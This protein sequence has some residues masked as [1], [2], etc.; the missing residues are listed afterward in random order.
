MNK[1]K[2]VFAQ[3]VDFLPRYEFD[4]I[5]KKYGGDY[6]YRHLTS[7]NHLLHLIFGQL[8]ACNSLR[9][10]CLCLGAHKTWLYHLGF[11]QSVNESSLSR[12]GE[13]RDYRIFEEFG[14]ILIGIARPLYV[15]ASIPDVFL[16]G[17]EVFALDST[18]ISCSILLMAWAFGKY[19]KGAV[20]MH[21]MLDL[22][23][24][25]P[26]FIHITHG[27]WHDSNVL[28]II[29]II[30]LAIYV[31]DKAYVDFEALYRIHA[32]NAYFVT[33]AKKNM[34]YEV[35][36]TNYNIDET[37]GLRGDYTIK[38]TG[39]KVKR[40][41]PEAFRLVKYYDCENDE[42]LDF[43]T[44]NLDIKALDVTNI[45]RN[46]WQIETFFKWIKGNLIIKTLW[47]HS[48]NAVKIHLW[49]AVIT[50]LLVSIIRAKTNSPYTITEVETLLRN[51]TF[52][53]MNLRDLLTKPAE[54][55]LDQNQNV[56]ELSLF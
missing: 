6:R 29:D 27:K 26:A 19:E 39:Y 17:W 24:S 21:T 9:D 23:G 56:K 47:G 50:Y 32:N 14:Y 48:E 20:K 49:V 36:E 22:R 40:F 33:R 28:D 45:Y 12:A 51:S 1:G 52:E 3:V 43:I 13:N 35:I 44:N 41:Y 5:V 38:L 37:T 18:T 25:I 42:E 16:P 55:F 30:P 53:R 4:K 7:Y 46:R 10:I 31:M 15:K 8:S 2:F 34:K 11:G 54:D